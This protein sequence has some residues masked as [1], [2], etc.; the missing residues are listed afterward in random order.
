MGSLLSF[1]GYVGWAK[2]PETPPEMPMAHAEDSAN[3]EKA[4]PP[5]PK[6]PVIEP[7][8]TGAA[9]AVNPGE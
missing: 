8:S 6:V 4:A 3:A 9:L 5:D 1:P 7:L 2:S